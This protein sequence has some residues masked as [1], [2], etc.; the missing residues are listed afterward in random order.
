MNNGVENQVAEPILTPIDANGIPATTPIATSAVAVEPAIINTEPVGA[1]DIPSSAPISSEPVLVAEEVP[2]TTPEVSQEKPVKKKRSILPSLLFILLV[3][4][5][6][7]TYF[8]KTSLERQIAELQYR[9][10]PINETKEEKELDINSTLVQDLYKKVETSIHE[11]YAQPEWNDTMKVYLAYRQIADHEMYDSHCNMFSAGRMEP[12]TCEVTTTF[13]PKAFKTDTLRLEWKKL[14]GEN[15]PMPLI[16]VKL[17]NGCIGGFEYIPE[18]DEYVQGYCKHQL[19]PS[20]KKQKKLVRAVTS[21]NT[22]ILTEEVTYQGNEKLTLPDYL[23]S[24]TYYYTF[25]LDMNY[26]YVLISKKLDQKY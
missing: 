23:V 14:F 17:E 3:A 25:R 7:F 5:G 1:M 21:R 20:F 13:I 10:S 18:R 12:Y 2:T 16:N 6:V 24:G 15:T 26:N 11:D 19:A 9:C 4:L 8:T 22:I